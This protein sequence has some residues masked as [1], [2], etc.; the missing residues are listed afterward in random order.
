MSM[1]DFKRYI[2]AV[3][4]GPKGNRELSFEESHDVMMQMLL[5]EAKGEQIAAFLLGWRLKGET[6][7]EFLGALA[8]L[9]TLTIKHSITDSI[10]LGYPFDGKAKNPYLLPKMLECLQK[11]SLKMVVSGDLLVPAKEGVTSKNICKSLSGENLVYFDRSEYLPQLHKLTNLRNLLGVRTGLN[12]IEKLSGVANSKSAITA[13]HHT[14]YVKKYLEIFAPRYERFAL[15]QG[16]EGS[17]EVFKKARLWLHTN[18]QTQELVVDPGAFGIENGE[19]L[20]ALAC[21]NAAVLLF[22]HGVYES[23]EEAYAS[24]VL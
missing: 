17:P 11:Q 10:E 21:L 9:D 23:V 7:E 8:A 18:G 4:T 16:D 13:V 14:P 20:D 2:K 3:G 19:D 12:T 15:V 6:S 22:V 1:H 24:L 5:G